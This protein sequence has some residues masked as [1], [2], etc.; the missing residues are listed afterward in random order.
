MNYLHVIASMNP[1]AGGPCQG[2]RNL[3][4]QALEGGHSLEVVCLDDPAAAYLAGEKI[5]VHALGQRRGAWGYHPALRPWLV[6]NLPRFDVVILNGLWL[7]PGY[8]LSKLAL[9]PNGP[10]YFVFPHGMLDPWFQPAPGRRWKAFRNWVYWK[11]I[12][13]HVIDRAAGI[14]FTCAE[15]LRLAQDTF[16]P[17]HPQQ[18]INVGYGVAQPP[19]FNP[20]MAA[21]FQQSCPGLNDRPYYIFLGRIDSKKGVDLLLEAYAA[22]HGNAAGAGVP[23]ANSGPAPTPA[24][25]VAGPG[26]DTEYGQ[27]MQQLAR[28][29]CPPAPDSGAR[30][31]V[32][33]PGM[34]TGDAKWGALYRASAF[35]LPSH[36][37][38]FGIAVVEALACATPVLIS[39]QVNIW[40]EIKADG[41]G[42]VA[43]DTAEGVRQLFAQWEHLSAEAK[44]A[45]IQA[46]KHSY[47]NR[48]GVVNA[49]RSLL[50]T[51]EELSSQKKTNAA[52][53]LPLRRLFS[54]TAHKS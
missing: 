29:L 22:V 19:E 21:A 31:A 1:R 20:R 4:A 44:Q 50:M 43:A 54:R 14:L 52:E 15:E 7:Y 30:P 11:L 17:Y 23:P 47:Y 28:K 45:M 40:R 16:R 13:R 51:L 34:L 27:R 37:E 39:N 6:E 5:T 49:A 9:Q 12:E 41:A 35:V 26:L 42:L 38:N 53:L 32:F 48:F 18:Q 25:V 36:Q 24:L 46:A 3:A 8:V 10:P 2:V 33:W